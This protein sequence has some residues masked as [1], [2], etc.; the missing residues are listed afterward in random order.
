MLADPPDPTTTDHRA[1][2]L[3]NR[4]LEIGLPYT[5]DGRTE[6]ETRDL[7]DRMIITTDNPRSENPQ[8]I[9]DALLKLQRAWRDNS[10]AYQPNFQEIR[11]FERRY[12]TQKL[13]EIFNALA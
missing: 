13:A 1:L 3:S 9:V 11:K 8:A 5:A 4:L 10:L 7:A 6:A 2:A 12:L